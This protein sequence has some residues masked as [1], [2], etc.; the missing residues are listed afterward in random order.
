MS[1]EVSGGIRTLA[2]TTPMAATTRAA[3]KRPRSPSRVGTR[4][5]RHSEARELSWARP[6]TSTAAS[7]AAT[8]ASP[9]DEPGPERLVT[10]GALRTLTARTTTTGSTARTPRCSRNATQPSQ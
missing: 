5:A 10:E 1:V 3:V 4:R 2:A 6:T 9:I 7:T 8:L